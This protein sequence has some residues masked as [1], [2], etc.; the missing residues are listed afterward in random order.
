MWSAKVIMAV[1]AVMKITGVQPLD[2]HN[3]IQVMLS[4]LYLDK[5]ICKY[6]VKQMDESTRSVYVHYVV[7]YSVRN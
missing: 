1:A 4:Y 7:Y 2:E 5:Y 3:T 6:V